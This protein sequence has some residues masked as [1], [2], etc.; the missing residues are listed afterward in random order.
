MTGS[1]TSGKGIAVELLLELQFSL[2]LSDNQIVKEKF[3]LNRAL[4]DRTSIKWLTYHGVIRF[5]WLDLYAIL[6]LKIVK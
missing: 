6:D 2:C 5:A 4:Q 1:M 3:F